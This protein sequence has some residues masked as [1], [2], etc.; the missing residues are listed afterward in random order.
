MDQERERILEDLRGIVD[1]EV[2]CDDLFL[3][4]FASDA[5]IYQIRPLAVVR[6]RS[7]ADVVACSEYAYTNNISLFPRGAG[8]GL[9][10]ESL[11]AGIVLDFSRYM[12]RVLR[13]DDETVRLQPGV[14]HAHLNRRLAETGRLFGPDPAMSRVTTMGSVVAVDAAGS[15]SLQFG[16][17][18]DHVQSMQVVLADGERMEAARESLTNPG[19]RSPR[20]QAIVSEIAS[21]IRDNR[22]L[23]QEHQPEVPHNRCG[24][25]LADVLTD[26]HL[27]LAK[28]LSGSEG[29]LA[30]TTEL[31]LRTQPLAKHRGVVLLLFDRLDQAA[32]AVTEILPFKPTACDLMDRRHL[33][34]ARENDVRFDLLIPADTE[35]LLLVEVQA[36]EIS[37]IRSRLRE[38]TARIRYELKLALGSRQTLEPEEIDLYWELAR[39]VVPT[40]HRLKGSTRPLPLV[41]DI[42]VRP[43]ALPEFFNRMYGV[44]KRH[45]VTASLFGHVGHGQL[46]VRPFL[47]LANREDATRMERLV[48]DLY[49]EVF[50]V[51]GTISGEHA[52]GLS[53][54]TFIREQYG[55]LYDLFREIKRIFDPHNV[56]NSGKVISD[57]SD[58]LTRNLRPVG[59][60]IGSSGGSEA[61]GVV[62]AVAEGANNDVVSTAG[63]SLG[64]VPLQLEWNIEEMAHA[65]RTCNG[66]G[67]CRTRLPDERMC[68]IFRQSAREEASPR[69]KANLLR[70]VLTGQL[71][72]EVV[73]T[74][75]FKEIVDLCVNCH[76]CRLECPASVDI[77][78]L[79][80]EAK[81]AYTSVNGLS[82]TDWIV[83]RLDLFGSL[84]NRFHRLANWV[85]GHRV[86]RWLLEKICGISQGRKLPRFAKT[87]FLRRAARRRLTQPGHRGSAKVLYFVDVFANHHDTKLAQAF[88]DVLEHNGVAVYVHPAQVQ[89]AMAMISLGAVEKAR[90]FAEQ[91]V[92]I[93]AEAIR[94]GYTIVT[95]EPAAGSCLV[96]EYPSMMKDEDTQ[97]VAENTRD[98]CDY[99]WKLHLKGKLQLDFKPVNATVAYH[100]PCH[101][102][103]LEVGSPGENLMRLIPGLVVSRLERG[104]S[105]MAGTFGLKRENYR[106]SLRAGFDLITGVRDP[107]IQAGTTE[108]SACKIQMEQGTTKP[109]I[110]PVKFLALAYGLIDEAD[111][112]LLARGRELITT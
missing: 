77:P 39:K 60:A 102:R 53:R 92:A 41:E 46:H 28:L 107:A 96:H 81:A 22:D 95:T 56:L 63:S 36:D 43:E 17:A 12:N 49:A 94:Q 5:S 59:A 112:P 66:C 27:D 34:L 75:E 64:P 55:P 44:L 98:A 29:T 71:E 70:G 38:V 13:I 101:L 30:T 20:K 108:C 79:I 80:L 40:L 109:T 61:G 69:A 86:A 103:S 10:G 78:K 65:A 25:Q 51:R 84:G 4:L 93:L 88:V 67:A 100:Q 85:I 23:I 91:N 21:L 106:A 73:T 99:L 76:Q 89:S 37:E 8:S 54:T 110:H 52:D 19:G 7:V 42:A 97:L 2:R 26:T 33:S 68:P 3:Q 32:A 74:D 83:S 11:G 50:A 111:S 18:R 6:P 48:E 87:S 105:G 62:G 14:V 45:H 15:H 57:E 90:R 9:A 35:A 72:P 16:S 24:Y 82:P 1:G 58:L 104:C 47:D 31:T